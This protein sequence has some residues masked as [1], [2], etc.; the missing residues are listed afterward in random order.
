MTL[1]ELRNKWQIGVQDFNPITTVPDLN[2]LTREGIRALTRATGGIQRSTTIT[3]IAGTR[4]YDT[5]N[6]FPTDFIA[7]ES[8][9]YGTIELLPIDRRGRIQSSSQGTPGYYYIWAR[10]IGFDIIPNDTLSITL[11]YFGTSDDVSS[12]SDIVLEELS[13]LDDDPL[14][15]A[16]TDYCELKYFQL[17]RAKAVQQRD[18]DGLL[19]LKS[20]IFD[21]KKEYKNSKAYAVQQI[22]KYNAHRAIQFEMP[23]DFFDINRNSFTERASN[24]GDITRRF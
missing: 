4:E 24:E 9:W 2:A 18:R 13:I 8:V 5:D 11:N 19:M 1:K 6:S 17:L 10:S 14:W 20:L 22:A 23:E 3:T 16:I 15:S 7:V 21:K 12:D